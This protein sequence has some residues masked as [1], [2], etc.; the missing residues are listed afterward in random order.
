M[1]FLPIQPIQPIQKM[2]FSQD[3]STM[4]TQSASG[5]SF[6]N[7]LQ[8]AMQN[9]EQLQTTSEQDGE[10]LAL[11]NVDD[12]SQVQINSM[13]AQSALQTAVQLTSRTVSAYKEIMQMTV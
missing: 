7:I 5:S 11:G 10:A 2:D 6:Q 3:N 9:Y 4:Q 12:L 13:K 1:V 8:Q